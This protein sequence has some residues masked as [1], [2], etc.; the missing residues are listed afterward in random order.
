MRGGKR[1]CLPGT[2]CQWMS[3]QGDHRFDDKDWVSYGIEVD[4]YR[5]SSEDR[6]CDQYA[7]EVE[8]G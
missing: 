5:H 8:H 7:V 2:K 1:I 4:T 3:Q 6:R